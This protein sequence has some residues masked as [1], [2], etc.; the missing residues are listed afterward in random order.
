[1]TPTNPV[2]TRPPGKDG[3]AWGGTEG[4]RTKA[5]HPSEGPARRCEHIEGPGTPASSAAGFQSLGQLHASW[6]CFRPLLLDLGHIAE[7]HRHRDRKLERSHHL[8]NPADGPGSF[9][10]HSANRK[11]RLRPTGPPAGRPPSS[12]STRVS[13][14]RT[15]TTPYASQMEAPSA[16]FLWAGV[17]GKRESR[18]KTKAR[19]AL[20]LPVPQAWA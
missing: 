4:P 6:L 16:P 1:M 18:T 14:R 17:A 13:C 8:V 9:R 5:G 20:S 12:A 3:G 11:P 2:R 15:P 10:S 19:S 7:N